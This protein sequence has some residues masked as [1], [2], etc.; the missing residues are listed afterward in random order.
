MK[1]RTDRLGHPPPRTAPLVIGITGSIGCGKSHVR[2]TLAE[3]GADG[4]DADI[5]AHHV[6]AP[7]GPAYEPLVAAFG[8]DVLR[9]DGVVDR[10]QLGARVFSD[11]A[12]LAQLEA[13]V[14]PAVIQEIRAR[15][16]ASSAPAV[17]IEAIKLLEV[18]LSASLCD[19]VWVV[20]CSEDDQ[21]ER[22]ACT[23]G[24]SAAELRRRRSNQMPQQKM[25]EAADRVIQTHGTLVETERCVLRAWLELGLPL[26]GAR[27]AGRRGNQLLI[28]VRVDAPEARAFYERLGFT[29]CGRLTEQ[30]AGR[31]VD[32][33]V[34][35]FP[36]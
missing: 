7:G 34:V 23:R 29:E 21:L 17:A 26:A 2:E 12:A 31:Y 5:V 30:I 32:Q 15:V 25:V 14:H 1:T 9:P 16:A 24:M 3:L 33:I 22:L 8:P 4:I 10:G 36:L 18:G 20:A 28:A 11:G 13:I 6:M 35:E 19:E 27:V